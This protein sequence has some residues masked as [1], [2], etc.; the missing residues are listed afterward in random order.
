MKLQVSQSFAFPT[1]LVKTSE[2]GEIQTLESQIDYV[3][4]EVR[5]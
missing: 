3:R 1:Q 5:T 4:S 2:R